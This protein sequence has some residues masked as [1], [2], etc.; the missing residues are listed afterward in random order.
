MH[1]RTIKDAL[2]AEENFF[3]S[4]P[5]CSH[6]LLILVYWHTFHYR[7]VY[8]HL[9]LFMQVYND[10]A[11][12]CGVPQLA[13]KLNQVKQFGTELQQFY[14]HDTLRFCNCLLVLNTYSEQ[15]L[16]FFALSLSLTHTDTHTHTSHVLDYFFMYSSC[17]LWP[18]WHFQQYE[19]L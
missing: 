15:V 16:V 18:V 17:P 9:L 8:L 7:P 14:M 1:N 19:I 5:V 4:R 11:D 13:K 12:R 10:I 2:V 3:R 6:Y